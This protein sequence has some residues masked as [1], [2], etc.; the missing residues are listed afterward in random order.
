MI[1]G[2]SSSSSGYSPGYSA[3]DGMSTGASYSRHAKASS[4]KRSQLSSLSRAM[5]WKEDAL[6]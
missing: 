1:A 5:F 4:T 6:E 3:H 2:L